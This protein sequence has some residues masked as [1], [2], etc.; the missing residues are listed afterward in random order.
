MSANIIVKATLIH[1]CNH[2]LR[3]HEFDENQQKD[4]VKINW[5]FGVYNKEYC[6]FNY[7]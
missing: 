6:V 5:V 3:V 1:Q 2:R 4:S 7:L